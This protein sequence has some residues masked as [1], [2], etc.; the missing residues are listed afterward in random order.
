MTASTNN[1][2]ACVR[3]RVCMHSVSANVMHKMM[4]PKES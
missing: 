1:V 4:N 3:S 2:C